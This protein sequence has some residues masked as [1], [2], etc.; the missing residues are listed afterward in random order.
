MFPGPRTSIRMAIVAPTFLLDDGK[1]LFGLPAR[2]AGDYRRDNL[3]VATPDFHGL[4]GG[5]LYDD[6]ADLAGSDTSHVLARR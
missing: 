4:P 3:L 1:E 5:A 2:T 6:L